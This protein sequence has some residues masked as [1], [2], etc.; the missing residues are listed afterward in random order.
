MFLLLET[1]GQLEPVP[2]SLFFCFDI[3]KDP[4]DRMLIA[5]AIIYKIVKNPLS[6]HS[7]VGGNPEFAEIARLPSTRE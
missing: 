1:K 3:H 2:L 5:Q 4:F 6:R 7:R